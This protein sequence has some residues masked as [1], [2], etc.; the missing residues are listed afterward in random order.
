MPYVVGV[1]FDNNPKVY[2]FSPN[3]LEPEVGQKVVVE[4]SRGLDYGTITLGKSEVPN[5]KIVGKLMP[6]VRIATKEDD[7][8]YLKLEEKRREAYPKIAEKI[9]ASGLEMKLVGAEYTFDG[10]KLIIYFTADGR[11]D[12]RNLVRDLASTFHTRIELK[13]IGARDECRMIGGIAPC[14][15]ACC[16]SDHI[17]EYSKVSIKMAK[18]QNLSLNPGKIS[19]LCGRLM[20]CLAYENDYYCEVC[21]IMPK[22]GASVTLKDGR[23]GTVTATN[24]LKK[25]V[26][27]KVEDPDKESFTIDD[28]ALD[29][30]KFKPKQGKPEPEKHDDSDDT[31]DL[32]ALKDDIY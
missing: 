7:E 12:F 26:K 8:K 22:V 27:V 32:S 28:Y 24:P 3:D 10:S 30:I 18:N 29:D 20:C 19:G 17:S 25:T 14:G 15:R 1:K 4:T 11:V 6:V 2:Y 21:K 31:D 13:Q 9:K 16:C 23:T 5:D